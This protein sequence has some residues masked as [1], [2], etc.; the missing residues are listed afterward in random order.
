[1]RSIQ[2]VAGHALWSALILTGSACSG[3]RD[4]GEG[5]G[6]TE[7]SEVG[8]FS[9]LFD[10]VAT[11]LNYAYDIAIV[12]GPGGTGTATE[13]TALAGDILI[14]NYGTSEVLR[15]P[16]PTD[17]AWPLAVEPFFDGAEVGLAGPM[18]IS[19]PGDGPVWVAFEWGGEGD[20]GGIAVLSP[21]PSPSA[22]GQ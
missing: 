12:P 10:N 9:G 3:D 14:A 21:Q 18:G 1:M 16:N 13:A 2:W 22:S 5:D 8:L 11:G 20:Q 15:V 17:A 6:G 7:T 19:V 4:D